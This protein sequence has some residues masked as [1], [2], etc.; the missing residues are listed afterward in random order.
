MNNANSCFL[1]SELH[2][3]MMKSEQAAGCT[4][5]APG[6]QHARAALLVCVLDVKSVVSQIAAAR[7][8]STSLEMQELE[9]PKQTLRPGYSPLVWVCPFKPPHQDLKRGTQ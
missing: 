3:R 8:A 2:V 9:S 6:L 7:L 4:G 1:N 5:A